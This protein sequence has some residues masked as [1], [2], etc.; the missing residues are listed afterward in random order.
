MQV[1]Q[2][3]PASEPPEPLLPR[4][5]A[6]AAAALV[7]ATVVALVLASLTTAGVINMTLA[8]ILLF[9]AWVVAVGG[10]YLLGPAW[11]L[12]GKHRVV[13]AVILAV[14]LFGVERVEVAYQP[15]Q[16]PEASSWFSSAQPAPTIF[17][18]CH[19]G[20]GPGSFPPEGRVSILGL[21]MDTGGQTIGELFGQAGTSIKPRM[22]YGCQLTNYGAAPLFNV[23]FDMSI[24]F[25]QAT[26]SN[27][28]S[29]SIERNNTILSRT[30]PIEISKVDV[31]PNS[32][33]GFYIEN[34][35][36]HY[37]MFSFPETAIGRLVDLI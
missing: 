20:T 16:G 32:S 24:S 13:F 14:L 30:V 21:S 28:N 23:A 10:T 22:A 4:L 19:F 31:G 15:Q 3:P 8:I 7:T 34:Y 11:K 25:V 9:L 6:D 1:H 12:T 27:E 37:V 33:F 26:K 5:A 29:L 2:T 18:E 35:S 36:P 17:I